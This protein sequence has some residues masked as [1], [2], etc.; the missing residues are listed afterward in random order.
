MC[1][2]PSLQELLFPSKKEKQKKTLYGLHCYEA[3]QGLY[4]DKTKIEVV[5]LTR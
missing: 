1:C 2:D 5:H 3:E 4:M